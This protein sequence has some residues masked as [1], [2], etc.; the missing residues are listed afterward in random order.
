MSFY[1]F[2]FMLLL[3]EVKYR[4]MISD[5]SKHQPGQCPGKCNVKKAD[6]ACYSDLTLRFF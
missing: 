2:A 5:L 1:F 4:R 3:I 6:A